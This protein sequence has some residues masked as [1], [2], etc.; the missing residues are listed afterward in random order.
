MP[1]EEIAALAYHIG[2]ILVCLQMNGWLLFYAVP[3]AVKIFENRKNKK[4]AE[5][6]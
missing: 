6:K 4:D 3:K 1:L 5:V 2:I